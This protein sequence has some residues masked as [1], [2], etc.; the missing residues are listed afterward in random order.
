MAKS[1][2]LLLMEKET[3]LLAQ[4]HGQMV[5]KTEIVRI[6]SRVGELEQTIADVQKAISETEVEIAALEA[7]IIS[8]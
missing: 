1:N 6:R 2:E 5:A 8:A 7:E 4:K 3:Q